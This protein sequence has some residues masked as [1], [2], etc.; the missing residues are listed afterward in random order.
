[1]D[2]YNF[3]CLAYQQRYVDICNK[4]S[5]SQRGGSHWDE[6]AKSEI[7]DKIIN[8]LSDEFEEKKLDPSLIIS[9]YNVWGLDRHTIDKRLPYIIRMIDTLNSDIVCLQEVTQKVLEE[10]ENN[11]VL[12]KKYLFSETDDE[13]D[14]KNRRHSTITLTKINPKDNRIVIL[15]YLCLHKFVI[16]ACDFGNFVI[17][18]CHL[19]ADKS[20]G[21]SNCRSNMIDYID[22][23]ITDLFPNK[24][25]IICGDF[26]FHLDGDDD[27][28]PEINHLNLL[29][30]KDS[31][32][33]VNPHLPGFTKD[34]CANQLRWNVKQSYVRHRTDGIFYRGNNLKI[35]DINMFGTNPVDSAN[36]KII[37]KI[38][39]KRKLKYNMILKNQ[40]GDIDIYP[41]DHFGLICNF[42]LS[43]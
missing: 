27:E 43:I 32:R 38:I 3:S 6:D 18:N 35:I 11:E 5:S 29:E 31:W 34:S 22:K 7:K 41:S 10:L 42:K 2:E 24:S 30:M 33:I 23:K 4:K 25:I 37:S 39:D 13:I 20:H 15:S 17:L 1:M 14:W 36:P 8:R 16:T 19:E 9:T 26:N 21:D 12:T 28:W 40:F